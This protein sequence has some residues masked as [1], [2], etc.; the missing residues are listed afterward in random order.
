MLSPPLDT[1]G[2]FVVVRMLPAPADACPSLLRG[3]FGKIRR[4]RGACKP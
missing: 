1:Y 2:V 3:E 4:K